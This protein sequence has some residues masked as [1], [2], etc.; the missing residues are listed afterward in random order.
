LLN[1]DPV[2]E[3]PSDKQITYRIAFIAFCADNSP[4]GVKLLQEIKSLVNID[5]EYIHFGCAEW[6]WDLQVNSFV[7]QVVPERYKTCDKIVIYHPEALHIEKIRDELL[8]QLGL[9]FK[10]KM[11]EIK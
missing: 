2:H 11:K 3:I 7:L 6:F 10:K 8:D 4:E 9:L 5:P 1:T